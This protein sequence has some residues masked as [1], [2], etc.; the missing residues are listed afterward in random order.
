MRQEGCWEAG[1]FEEEQEADVVGGMEER[2]GW[3]LDQPVTDGPQ[4]P[5]RLVS[6]V[7]PCWG[8]WEMD[9]EQQRPLGLLP[10][11]LWR[12]SARWLPPTR[13]SFRPLR[14]R[15]RA[16]LPQSCPTLCDC[17]PPGNSVHGILQARLLELV[18]MPSSRGSSQPRDQTHVSCVS[19]IGR[20]FLYP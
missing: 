20:R 18:A 8:P 10:V 7:H 9:W 4:C 15:V 16:K 2:G 1:V 5:L 12:E 3:W 17:S 13:I 19:C 11:V 6:C 14:A